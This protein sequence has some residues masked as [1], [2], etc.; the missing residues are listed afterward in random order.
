MD[1]AVKQLLSDLMI[2]SHI[3][4]TPI[5]ESITPSSPLNIDNNLLDS[6]ISPESSQHA[7]P[8]TRRIQ[9]IRIQFHLFVRPMIKT[10]LILFLFLQIFHKMNRI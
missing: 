9:N 10:Q 2:D 5:S 3:P 4:V 1:E 6:I 8:S 7:D